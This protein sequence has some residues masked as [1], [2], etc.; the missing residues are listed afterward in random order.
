MLR[1]LSDEVR[2]CYAHADECAHKAQDAFTAEMREDFLRLQKSWLALARSY[3]FAEQ[4]L[5]FSRENT[6]SRRHTLQ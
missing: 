5:D 6:R 2:E 1:K 4:L 3:E